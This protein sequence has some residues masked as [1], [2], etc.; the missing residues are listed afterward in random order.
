MTDDA[1]EAAER[2]MLAAL[3]EARRFL[4]YFARGLT[5]FVGGGTPLKA[6]HQ[7][8]H[9]I[10][11]ADIAGIRQGAAQGPETW[12]DNRRPLPSMSNARS[13]SEASMTDELEALA[14]RCE[15]EAPSRALNIAISTAVCTHEWAYTSSLDAAARLVPEGLEWNL[16]NLHGIAISEA[17]L[18]FSDGNWQTGRHKG[19]HLALALCAAALR[20]RAVLAGN[21]PLKETP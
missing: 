17:G 14:A 10:N 8:K 9:A 21:V 7:V 13:N 1:R 5:T 16:T 2:E 11:A 3:K 15:R 6:L 20:T 19:G 12:A 4:D 18:N